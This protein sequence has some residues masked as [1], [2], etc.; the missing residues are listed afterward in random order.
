MKQSTQPA[1][2]AAALGMFSA[3]SAV[4]PAANAAEV[5]GPKPSGMSRSGAKTRLTAGVEKLSALVNE[6][7]G[8]NFNIVLHGGAL[9]KSR[10]NLDGISIDAFQA[11]M[12]CFYHPKKNRR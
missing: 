6:K 4:A 5:D 10:E 7:T 11:A 8:G 1:S 3:G 2:L 9:S 12:F